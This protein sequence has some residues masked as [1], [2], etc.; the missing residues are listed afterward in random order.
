MLK[1]YVWLKDLL[2]NERGQDMVEYAL[3]TV[4]ISVVIVLAVMAI[5]GDAFTNWATD[6]AAIIDPP[7]PP[8]A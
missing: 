3:I 4:V 1:L 6:L 7:A 8:P 2:R 5:L